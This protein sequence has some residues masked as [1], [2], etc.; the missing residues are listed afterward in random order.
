MNTIHI[1]LFAAT[2]ILLSVSPLSSA[3]DIPAS[4]VAEM[5]EEQKAMMTNH[6]AYSTPNENHAL[7]KTMSGNWSAE[8]TMWMAAGS[9]GETSASSATGEMIFDGKFL[10]QTF[11]GAFMGQP[12]EGRGLIGYDNIRKEYQTVWYD[13]M[14][15][16][17]M[18]G[19]GKYNPETK[20]IA[21]EGMM[22]CPITN[23]P[24]WHRSVTTLSDGNNYTYETFM[25]DITSGEEFRSMLIKYT[26]KS[27]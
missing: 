21:E 5:T 8:I 10:Q 22:S 3:E 17:I 16:G 14:G 2:I 15:T 7:L 13:N 4:A 18:T 25:K 19:A 26:R 23:A 12:Y 24:R 11:S 27:E 20:T 9:E 6:K 1:K